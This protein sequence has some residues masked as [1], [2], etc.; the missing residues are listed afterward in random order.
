MKTNKKIKVV[1][2]QMGM[3]F[4]IYDEAGHMLEGDF[5]SYKAAESYAN[6]MEWKVVS[7]FYIR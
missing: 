3:D 6:D 1:I 2:E 7:N 4:C 5:R